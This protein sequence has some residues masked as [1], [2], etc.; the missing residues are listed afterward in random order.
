[1]E[2]N[3]VPE[4]DV[5]MCCLGHNVV[6]ATTPTRSRQLLR[7]VALG[8]IPCASWARGTYDLTYL[9]VFTD[10]FP[11]SRRPGCQ[12]RRPPVGSAPRSGLGPCRGTGF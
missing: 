9:L 10:E 7:A 3:P 8:E 4:D 12:D 11:K 6:Y 2:R 5:L 1:M